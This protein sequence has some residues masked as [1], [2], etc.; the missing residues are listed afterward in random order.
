MGGSCGCCS[1]G[2]RET[3][4]A[5]K[6]K[7]GCEQRGQHGGATGFPTRQPLSQENVDQYTT[8]N[9]AVTFTMRTARRGTAARLVLTL[10]SPH[11]RGNVSKT[12]A[13]ICKEKRQVSW[14]DLTV[15]VITVMVGEQFN[16]NGFKIIEKKSTFRHMYCFRDRKEA[17]VDVNVSLLVHA[18]SQFSALLVKPNGNLF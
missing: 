18:S 14:S 1:A 8:R 12:N 17:C 10:I 16:K 4:T 11:R 6:H 5:A 3:P 2:E 7:V 15:G 9:T 13:K